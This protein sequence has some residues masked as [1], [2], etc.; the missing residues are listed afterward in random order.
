[1]TAPNLDRAMFAR[2]LK[3]LAALDGRN[4]TQLAAWFGAVILPATLAAGAWVSWP[5]APLFIAKVGVGAAALYALAVW[6][7]RKFYSSGVTALG[8][9]PLTSFYD[10]TGQVFAVFPDATLFESRWGMV[11]S[12][13]DVL[14][15]QYDPKDR[16]FALERQEWHPRKGRVGAQEKRTDRIELPPEMI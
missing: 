14:R 1:M 7:G 8:N 9:A 13:V 3:R 2:E 5:L 10:R 15:L 11:V 4:F 16:A 6:G 12:H